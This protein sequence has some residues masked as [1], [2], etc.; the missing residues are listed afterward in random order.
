MGST[1]QIISIILYFMNL[2]L[3]IYAAISMILR[4][5]DPI[6]TLSWV[7][8]L[9]LLP[10][11]G[12][13]FYL[14]FG[15]NRRK[16]KIFSRKGVGDYRLR[17][18]LSA[19]QAALLKRNPELLGEE[20]LPFKKIIFQNLRNSSTLIEH[21][22]N[23][24]FYFSG[25]DALDAMYSQIEKAQQHIHLQSYIFT[26]DFTGRK[27]RD[28][29]IKKAQNGIEVRVIYDGVGSL[30][31]S[32]EFI[33]P[34]QA[35]G[36][37]VLAFSPIKIF[38]I[39]FLLNYRNHRKI[40]IIDGQIGFIGGVNIADR[41]YYGT[42]FGIWR[43]THIKIKGEAV[44]SL[45]ASFLLDRYF[46]L[47]RK[48]KKWKKYYPIFDII[49]NTTNEQLQPFY[50][51]T[52]TSGPDSSWASIMQCYF[53][54]ITGA[55][56]H[57]YIVTPY[58]TPNETI[59]DALKIAALGNVEVRLM[60]PDKSDTKLVHWCT[61]SYITELLEAGVKIYLFKKGFN[62][63]K[64][65]SI[66]GEMSIVGSANMDMRSFE[67]NFEIMSII[68]NKHCANTIEKQFIKDCNNC[69]LVNINKWK[70]RPLNNKIKESLS[71]LCSPLL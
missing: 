14:F 32:K 46:I 26:D 1:W 17:K 69:T 65:I 27:F 52:I 36:I 54:A 49:N 15:R 13:V 61:M 34:M 35:A 21:N 29:L 5:R 50:S 42:S 37:E 40:L 68:Y 24:E 30:S 57:I 18:S 60:I 64:V 53:T 11:I 23:I 3:A 59:L 63:S 43:D 6:K 62:H 51:Q 44:F 4:K 41:Y 33:K 47:N 10:Y 20:L 71:R 45:Q 67:H 19:N 55:K 16:S 48:I 56:D 9:I 8:V 70:N 2:G 31:L 58:F 25:K 7:T 12:V 22:S 39:K 38:S 28:L 66:D